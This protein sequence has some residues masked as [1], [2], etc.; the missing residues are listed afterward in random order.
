MMAAPGEPAE[1]ES[2]NETTE[3]FRVERH[4]GRPLY[5]VEKGACAKNRV[6]CFLVVKDGGLRN[7]RKF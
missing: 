7:R 1:T 2:D 3:V 6:L 5:R 4:V